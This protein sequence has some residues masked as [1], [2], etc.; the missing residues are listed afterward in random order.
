MSQQTYKREE[1]IS[2]SFWRCFLRRWCSLGLWACW[3][4]VSFPPGRYRPR[5][6]WDSASREA[7]H[8]CVD[9][10]ADAAVVHRDGGVGGPAVVEGFRFHKFLRC[11]EEGADDDRA[12]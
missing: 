6:H 8:P 9:K 3:A 11:C 5:G 12:R 7:A 10:G 4:L 2:W 1:L